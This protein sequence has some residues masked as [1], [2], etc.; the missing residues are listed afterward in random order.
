MRQREFKEFLAAVDELTPTQHE[1]LR[2]LV[3]TQTTERSSYRALE[4][5]LPLTC[6]DPKCG[7]GT[8]VR[9]G[10]QNGLQRVRCRKCNKTW[11]A[12]SGTLLSRVRHK[13]KL[14]AFAQCMHQSLSIRETAQRIGLST[15]TVF[16]WRH[17]FLDE[18]VGHQPQRVTGILE[19]DETYFRRSQKGVSPVVG[20]KPRHRGERAVGSGRRHEDFVPVLVGRVRG[21]PLTMDKVLDRVSAVE[22]TAA[23]RNVV[24]PGDTIVCTDKSTA[25][26]Q[27]RRNLGVVTKAVR[28][29]RRTGRARKTAWHVQSANSYHERLKT[30]VQRGLRGVSTKH[31]PRYLAWHRMLTWKGEGVSPAGFIV[32]AMGRRVINV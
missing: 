29:G 2:K 6:G 14:D 20:R 27:L 32:S 4:G 24:T 26:T 16:R 19:V 10:C 12:A 15:D 17:R 30:W 3:V 25:F 9:N 1:Q 23:L 18:V 22:V 5:V 13:E 11:N 31:L 7:P 28:G 8:V 21:Q